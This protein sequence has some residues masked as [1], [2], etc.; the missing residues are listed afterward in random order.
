[1][2]SLYVLLK[3]LK[4]YIG[5]TI[6]RVTSYRIFTVYHQDNEG[7]KFGHILLVSSF[8]Q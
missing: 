3:M 1:M 8:D 4:I 6:Y 7:A 2:F 5:F